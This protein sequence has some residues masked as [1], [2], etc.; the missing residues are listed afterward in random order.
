MS[1]VEAKSSIYI[2]QFTLKTFHF[3]YTTKNEAIMTLNK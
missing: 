2:S 3:I 1:P